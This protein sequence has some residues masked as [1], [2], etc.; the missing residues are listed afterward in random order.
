[1]RVLL[2]LLGVALPQTVIAAE[3]YPDR[4]IRFL[5]PGASGS[6]QDVLSR[7]VGSKLS[8]QLGQ[9]VVVDVRAGASGVIGIELGKAAAPDGYTLIAATTTLFAT[10]P[11]LNA[12]IPYDAD[13]DFA[14]LSRMASVANVMTVNAGIGVN[15]IADLVK[16]AKAKPRQLNYGSA[17]N[18][19]PA[20]LAGAMFDSLAGVMTT[21]VPYKGAA[22]A[23]H[24]AARRDAARKKRPHQSARHDRLETR[25][26]HPRIAD[27]RGYASGLRNH[28]VVGCRRPGQNAAGD[29]AQA[30]LRDHQGIAIDRS[31][32]PRRETGREC[33][34]GVAGRI[35]RVH[36]R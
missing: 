11:A 36:A 6:S 19:S 30:A 24:V 2:S 9:Q 33:T 3:N 31:A 1:M 7:I 21:H 27:R 34:T 13:K 29:R 25:S 20:H 32:R 14:P 17:G 8:Q 22:Q 28:A 15:N 4:P 5:V 23:K 18:A 16:L 10:L 26:A 12:K 35:Y